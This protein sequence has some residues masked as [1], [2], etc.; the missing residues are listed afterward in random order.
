MLL[1]LAV[2][3]VWWSIAGTAAE[4]NLW[5]VIVATSRYWFNYRH[6]ANGV[7]V[8]KIVRS[9]GVPDSRIIFMNSLDVSGEVRNPNRGYVSVSN[10]VDG[11]EWPFEDIEVDYAMEEVTAQSF[12]RFLS[13]RPL[14]SEFSKDRLGSDA[15]SS[16]LLFLA[17]HGGDEFFK[18]HDNEEMSAQDLAYT[19]QEMHVKGMY[20]QVLLV[21]DTCQASTMATYITAPHVTTLASSAKGENSYAYPT[22]DA[23]GVATV[24]RFT[25]SLYRFFRDQQL[26]SPLSPKKGAAHSRPPRSYRSLSLHDLHASFQRKLLYSTPTIVSSPGARDP[27]QLRLMEFFGGGPSEEEGVSGDSGDSSTHADYTDYL[28]FPTHSLA[29]ESIS[30]DEAVADW[31]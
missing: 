18:F 26:L 9:L 1:R 22:S 8:Y 29:Y 13:G 5:V 31:F 14:A 10:G 15:N 27:K 30:F 7:A 20:K 11:A 28:L 16:L 3:A 2:C 19:L 21:L 25:Y 17:G 12:L 6:T 23:L 24:D 4:D